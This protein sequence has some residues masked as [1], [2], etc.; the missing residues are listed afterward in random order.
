MKAFDLKREDFK[1]LDDFY[2][3]KYELLE[4]ESKE[5]WKRIE[6]KKSIPDELIIKAYQHFSTSKN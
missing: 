3:A 1:S 4:K 6:L 2:Q 5:F